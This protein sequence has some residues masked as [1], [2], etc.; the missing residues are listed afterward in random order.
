MQPLVEAGVEQRDCVGARGSPLRGQ[1]HRPPATHAQGYGP[2]ADR[3][4]ELDLDLGTEH[5]SAERLDVGGRDPRRA[6]P[7][8]DLPR[9][10]LSR[11][12][13]LERGGVGGEARIG[14][15]CRLG[16]GEL[17][18]DVPRKVLRRWDERAGLGVVPH[19]VAEQCPG[20]G[21]GDAEQVRRPL[22]GD[23]AVGV[24]AHRH[25]LGWRVHA[26]PLGGRAD[27]PRRKDLRLAGGLRL[28]VEHLE[29]GHERPVRVV[30]E[31]AH[32]RPDTSLHLVA[33]LGIDA[34]RAGERVAVERPVPAH[35]R[36]V[37]FRQ[38]ALRG[39]E[40][41]VVASARL[42]VE[43]HP[44]RVAK[45][46]ERPKL[47]GVPPH[48]RGV[49]LGPTVRHAGEPVA[50]DHEAAVGPH[51]RRWGCRVAG[52]GRRVRSRTPAQSTC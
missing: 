45:A 18:P 6:E 25:C 30:A 50:V 33:G 29:G 31:A 24:H 48:A 38:G 3:R 2:P 34:A 14:L 11:Q 44:G 51:G 8:G 17:G 37:P 19:Q 36:L 43:H 22:E 1:R 10:E 4:E 49:G 39:V 15:R 47:S 12:H 52:C 41:G 9:F 42:D 32:A 16:G 21:G 27:H 23:P 40:L 7:G 20:F 26:E 46:D 5:L 28:V 13:A 35:V